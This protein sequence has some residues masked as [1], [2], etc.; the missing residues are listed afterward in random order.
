MGTPCVC[1]RR[2][3][4]QCP[5]PVRSSTTKLVSAIF[6]KQMK[7]FW[8][9]LAEVVYSARVWTDHLCGS[10][11]RR[12]RSHKPRQIWRPALRFSS[13]S[14]IHLRYTTVQRKTTYSVRITTHSHKFHKDPSMSSAS[15][16]NLSDLDIWPPDAK[17]QLFRALTPY[18]TYA[19]LHQNWFVHFQNI[20][21]TSLATAI[22]NRRKNG[23]PKTMPRT[24]SLVQRRNYKC[25]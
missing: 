6:W 12:S 15:N 10:G 2:L 5:Q 9:Q 1:T 19:N 20:V 7:R 25:K 18:T 4:A 11:I 3:Q 16:E 14:S 23:N 22:M 24:A 8:W 21:H 17:S 13:L